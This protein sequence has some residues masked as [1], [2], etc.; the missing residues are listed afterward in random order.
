MINVRPRTSNPRISGIEITSD[1]LA[2]RGGMLPLLR[3]VDGTGIVEA[4]ASPLARYRRSGKG[5]AVPCLLRQ[6]LAFL[7]D[8]TS[9]RIKR[10][11]ELKQDLGYSALLELEAND[12]ASSDQVERFLGKIPPSNWSVHRAILR[13]MFATRLKAE[14][15]T[16]VEL[17]LDTMVLDNNDAHSRQGCEPTYKKVKGFQPLQLIWNGLVVDAQFRGGKK[18]GNHASTA[19]TMIKKARKII[20]Q[21]LGYEVAILVR[22]DGGFFDGSLFQALDHLNIGFVASGRKTPAIKAFVAQQEAWQVF[23]KSGQE[24]SYLDFGSRCG[25]WKKFFRTLYLKPRYEGEQAY[26]EFAR[27]E[28]VIL[29]NLAPHRRIMEKLD[30]TV[31]ERLFDARFLI[32][33]HHAKGADELTHRAIKDFG[34]EQM[35]FRKFGANMAFYY[36]MI[37]AHN[38]MEWYK[39]DVLVPLNLVGKRSYATTIRRMV[40]DYAA[41]IVKTGRRLVMKVTPSTM[42]RLQLDRLWKMCQSP[43]GLVS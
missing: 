4:L 36:L 28:S 19:L 34:F 37:I 16:T 5:I 1:L 3:Y 15:P 27:P 43:P 22:M 29:T 24:W 8:G 31:R 12:M 32:A 42:N 41:K 30:A 13:K 10:F 6:I 18:N 38:L 2:D 26:L 17:F 40:L 25:S 7:M 35:P 9:R 20:R 39:R 21:T 14:R 11:D 33:E 23:R